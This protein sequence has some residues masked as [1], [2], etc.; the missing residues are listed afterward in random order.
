MISQLWIFW[1]YLL[2]HTVTNSLNF[3]CKTISIHWPL[4]Y[5]F[6]NYLRRHGAVLFAKKRVIQGRLLSIN[7]KRKLPKLASIALKCLYTTYW[8]FHNICLGNRDRRRE[9]W[10]I[11]HC[12]KSQS[13]TW[14][15][16]YSLYIFILNREQA[17]HCTLIFLIKQIRFYIQSHLLLS[18]PWLNNTHL[19][20]LGSLSYLIERFENC[21]QL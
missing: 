8:L 10:N 17:L 4:N 18:N 9:V 3:S 14:Q 13:S 19:F 21:D 5:Q 11:Y 12:I 16:C 2:L 1:N 7:L 15:Y 6:F 20:S